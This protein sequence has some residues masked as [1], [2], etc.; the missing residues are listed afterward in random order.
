M[1]LIEINPINDAH[2]WQCVQAFDYY[3]VKQS[4]VCHC[5]NAFCDAEKAQW[6]SL[7][8]HRGDGEGDGDGRAFS[9]EYKEQWEAS[10][11]RQYGETA[12]RAAQLRNAFAD[13]D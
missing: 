9:E 4:G 8:D 5:D 3:I 6:T 10:Q 11:E 13:F 1:K 7:G 12:R 2:A